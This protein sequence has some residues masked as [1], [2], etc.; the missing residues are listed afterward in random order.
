MLTLN[1]DLN[2][3]TQEMEYNG[4]ILDT[5]AGEEIKQKFEQQLIEWERKVN[6][7]LSEVAAPDRNINVGSSA[8]LAEALYGRIIP[9][10]NKD[11]W[12]HF[13][14]NFNP[15]SNGAD[16]Q[17]KRAVLE[18]ARL[19]GYGFKVVPTKD[20]ITSTG[21]SAS[22]EAMEALHK[23]G[24]LKGQAHEFVEAFM[25]YSKRQTWLN[26]NYWALVQHVSPDGAVHSSFNQAGT[27]TGR[28]SSNA[29]NLLNLPSRKKNGGENDI[30]RMVVSRFGGDGR[31]CAP[32]FSQ[33]ELRVL[34]ELSGSK[35]G[36]YDYENDI[37]IHT[38]KAKWA[39]DHYFG[40]GTWESGTDA[41]RTSWRDE[42]KA[43]NFGLIYGLSPKD[44]LQKAMFD[45][46]HNDYPE[47]MEWNKRVKDE[48]LS[49]KYYQ[50][51][52]TGMQYGFSRATHDN[53]YRGY[54]SRG[55]GWKNKSL[56]FPVQGDAGRICQVAMIGIYNQIKDNQDIVF[57]GQVYDQILLDVHVNA[58]DKA[59]EIC[60]NN[61]E[62]VSELFE[63]YFGN[64]INVPI[65]VEWSEGV[66]WYE[67]N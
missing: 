48:I 12:K 42:Q 30:R 60:L 57:L 28:Y 31:I 8:Q 40:E 51:P 54:D 9:K 38:S 44:D 61:M 62:N 29:P 17:L 25:Q 23:S 53:F 27:R 3:V 52:L 67:C 47:V 41:E 35:R 65:K 24:K 36:I 43:V 59:K 15:F 56:N 14:D 7:L 26:S 49:R 39:V 33:I 22:A 20:Q 58:L 64:K 18:H 63:H 32:D 4:I 1:R 16:E 6:G 11:A 55:R 2:S 66:N 5:K 45:A 50:S 34:F 13:Y 37:D 46:F 10:E 21:F 19:T